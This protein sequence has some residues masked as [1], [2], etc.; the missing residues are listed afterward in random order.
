MK[1]SFENAAIEFQNFSKNLELGASK[2]RTKG[3]EKESHKNKLEKL[4]NIF[5]KY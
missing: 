3:N 2:T 1:S 5:D 4:A